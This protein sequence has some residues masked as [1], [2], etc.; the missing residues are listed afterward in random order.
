MGKLRADQDAFGHEIRDHHRGKGGEE[1]IER[2][3]GFIDTSMGPAAYFTEY[4]DWRVCDRRAIDKARGRVLDIGCGAGRH[5]LY[6]QS[7]GLD[8]LGIDVSPLGLK[9]CRLRGLRNTRLASITDAGPHWGTFDTI[10]MFGNNFGLFG[11]LARARALLRRFH[12]MTSAQARLIVQS[13]DPYQTD[14]PWHKRYQRQ[15]RLT[16][17]MPG[18]VR[19]RVRY[20]GWISPWFDYLLV[21]QDEMRMILEPTGWQ[22]TRFYKSPEPGY[23][24]LIEKTKG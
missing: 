2:S 23:T 15:N 13:L 6:L 19:I 10:V 8:V 9:T 5:A 12:R 18:Q 22:V 3:D 11:S 4:A 16:S 24:A 7:K 20:K 14:E 17:R 1:I 21:S